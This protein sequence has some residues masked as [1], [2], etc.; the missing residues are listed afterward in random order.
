MTNYNF[1]DD[2]RRVLCYYAM[3]CILYIV[4]STGAV[5]YQSSQNRLQCLTEY[6]TGFLFLPEL[7]TGLDQLIYNI[8]KR[9][10]IDIS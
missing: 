10:K 7:K 2:V 4:F 3:Q 1:N 5:C 6:C 8:L 9:N